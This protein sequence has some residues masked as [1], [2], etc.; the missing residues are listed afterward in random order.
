MVKWHLEFSK[1]TK[2]NK[3]IR[4]FLKMLAAYNGG[5]T[6]AETADFSFIVGAVVLQ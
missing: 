1:G 3:R 4:T 2:E 6:A 5:I